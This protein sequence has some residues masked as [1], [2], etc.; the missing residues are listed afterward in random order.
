MTEALWA[1]RNKV[2]CETAPGVRRRTT[3]GSPYETVI[4]FSR[5]IRVGERILVSG[6]GPVEPD[7]TTTPGDAGEQAQRV[8]AVI[9][10]AIAELG[11]SAGDVVRT[12]IFLTDPADAEAVGRA[13]ARWF[14]EARPVATMIVV[15][16]L[17]RPEWRVEVEAE[18]VVGAA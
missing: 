13:H 1:G 10:A 3:S 6:T 18:A 4:G 8:F 12:R 9:V 14:G 2:V 7:G 15:A 5:A 11:G 16:A 17:L